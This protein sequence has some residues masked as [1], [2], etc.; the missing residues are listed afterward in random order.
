MAKQANRKLIGGFV[1]AAVAIM[2][3][4][5]VIFGSGQFFKKK[6]QY[7]LYFDGS[8]KGLNVGAPVLFKGVQVGSV[9]NVVIRSYPEE[10]KSTI[11]VFIEVYPEQFEIIGDR[12]KLMNM[13]ERAQ[14]LIARG[15]RAQLTSV[16]LITGQLAIEFDYRPGTPVV[17]RKMDI[18]KDYVELP[19]IPSTLA[20]LGKELEKLDLKEIEARINSILASI[21]GLLKNQEIGASLR[22][23]RG[24]LQD[25]RGLVAN[26]NGKVDPLAENLN[27]TISDARGLVDNVDQQVKPLAGK[28]ASAM[29]DISKLARDVDARVDPLSK[30]LSDTL[31]SVESAFKSIDSLVGKDSPTRAELDRT[32]VELSGASRSLRILAEYLEQHPESLIKGKGY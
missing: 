1:L 13:R 4:S 15:L 17:L 16:S 20:R 25:A 23:L 29:E 6:Q 11:P 7:V 3:A 28:A 19:T 2:A 30:Q 32:L 31:K 21:D 24:L 9:T 18:D 26:V 12:E 27:R 14:E 10:D 5:V 8:V 22:E